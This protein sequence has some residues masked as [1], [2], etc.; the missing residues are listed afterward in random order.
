MKPVLAVLFVVACGND[1]DPRLIAGGGIGDGEIDGK[2]NVYVIDNTTEEPIANATVHVGKVEDTTDETGLVVFGDL[3]GSQTI[4]V[5]ADG[6][7]G[8]VWAG[9]NG[10][11]VTIPI[12]VADD[13]PDQATL[14]GSIPGWTG[15]DVQP[16]HVKAALITYSQT[17][18]LGDK[19]NNI[20]QTGGG[21]VCGIGTNTC[22]WSVVTRTGAVTLIAM[23]VDIDT[24][25]T[26]TSMDDTTTII[27][28][29][30]L[31]GLSVAKGVNQSG[32]QLTMI[33]AGN[34][35]NVSIDLGTPP[36][37]LTKT[38]SLVGVELAGGEVVQ[39]PTFIAEDPSAVLVPKGD[40]FAPG[41]TYRLTALASTT[42]GDMGAQSAVVRHGLTGT[43]LDAGEWLTPPTGVT[44]TRTN[45][46]WDIVTD[47]AVHQMQWTDASS[48]VVLEISVF[49]TKLTSIDIPALVALPSS[50]QLTG[51]LSGIGADLDVKNFSLDEDRDKLWGISAQPVTIP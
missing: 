24:K 45:A 29:A 28:W 2:L 38:E 18:Q 17:D 22:N 7:R 44:M 32:L 48:N 5:K 51:K 50:G 4:S 23:I 12:T 46:S 27:G 26:A 14:S 3:S 13:T 37:A 19:A 42:S 9:A 30:F 39:L 8:T 40:V 1:P 35:N 31:G 21:N 49:D 43:S 16:M 36:A 11:N 20:P 41:A 34:L 10:A 47:A 33:E 6:Y 15:T 25:G